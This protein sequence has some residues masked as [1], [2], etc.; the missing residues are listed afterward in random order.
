MNKLKILIRVIAFSVYLILFSL[1]I[2][3]EFFMK[4]GFNT[5]F[6]QTLRP[7]VRNLKDAHEVVTYHFDTKFRDL[8]RSLGIY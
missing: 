5:Y 4:E 8:R 1:I 6:R 2:K 3:N 7:Q